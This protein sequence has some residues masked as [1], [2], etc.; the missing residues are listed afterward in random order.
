MHKRL[1]IIIAFITLSL[2]VLSCGGNNAAK[3]KFADTPFVLNIIETTDTHG[4]IFPYNFITDKPEKNS[5]ANVYSYIETLRKENKELLLLDCGDSLQGQPTVYYYNFVETNTTHLWSEVLNYIGYDAVAVGNH[6]VEAG[7]AVY[8]KMKKELKAPL[9]AA[10]LVDEKTDKPYFDAYTVVEKNGLKIA[11]LGLIEPE[12]DLQLPR[13]LYSG[14]KLLDMVDTAKKWVPIIMKKEKPDLLIGLFHAGVDY[15]YGGRSTDTKKNEN[16]S[17]LVAEKVEGFDIVFV[18]HDHQGWSGNGYSLETKKSTE[19]VKSPSGK[20]I[21]IFGGVNNT[22]LIASVEI[23]MLWDKNKK[24]WIKNIKG[25]LVDTSSFEPSKDFL[26][27]F[28]KQ[29]SDIK[30]WVSRPIG[31]LET[32]LSSDE[33]MFGDSYFLSL[34]HKLQFEIAK[35]KLGKTVDISF[36]APLSPTAKLE[37]GTIRVRDMFSLYPYENFFYVMTLKGSQIKDAM[38][39]SYANW[40]NT[41]TNINDHLIAFNLDKDGKMIFN[42][43]YNSYDTK[44][45]AYNYESFAGLNYTVDITKPAGERITISSMTDGSPFDQ[46][47]EYNVAINSYRGSGGGGHLSMG[48]KIPVK[49]L[50]EMTLVQSSTDKDLRFYMMEWFENQSNSIVVEK[51]GNWKLIPDDFVEAGKKKDYPLLYPPVK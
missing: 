51:L 14:M 2:M 50:Q 42:P 18:G 20:I 43:R 15:S 47:K 31:T 16:A 29:Q 26:D 38:E 48:A 9:L 45:R 37:K 22:R 3:E 21:P 1:K 49:D 7:H 32:A 5:T 28:A 25:E 23:S 30:E 17:Q 33:A 10:N 4:M 41:M 8:D 13:V 12:V 40:F 6:D 19:T 34:I 44:T 11:I 35:D 36:A 39:Y 46:E 24:E 27:K